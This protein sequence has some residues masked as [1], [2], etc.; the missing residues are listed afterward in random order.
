MLSRYSGLPIADA[1]L[2]SLFG[3]RAQAILTIRA[4]MDAKVSTTPTFNNAAN[5]PFVYMILGCKYPQG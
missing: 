4:V 3:Y 2:T 1:K 5:D